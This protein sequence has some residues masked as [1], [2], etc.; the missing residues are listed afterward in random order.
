MKLEKE[1]EVTCVR[2]YGDYTTIT[3]TEIVNA[4]RS[5]DDAINELACFPNLLDVK[6]DLDYSQRVGRH[7]T[8][9]LEEA[10]E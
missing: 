7:F 6:V 4:W 8:I 2:H 3:L 9:T 5:G 1:Y 10:A